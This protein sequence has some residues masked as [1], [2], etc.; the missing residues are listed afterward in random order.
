[1]YLF[2]FRFFSYLA[3]IVYWAEFSVL[4]V[5]KKLI[6]CLMDLRMVIRPSTNSKHLICYQAFHGGS[7]G[8]ES[9]CSAWTEELMGLDR[10]EWLKLSLSHLLP[11]NMWV[12]YTVHGVLMTRVCVL[13]TQS[14]PTL[15]DPMDGSLSGSSV[16]AEYCSHL[17]SPPPMDHVLVEDREV[18]SAA[19][20]GVKESQTQ[21]SDWATTI[22]YLEL[23]RWLSGKESACQCRRW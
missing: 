1:M 10:I 5:N 16:H 18:W 2:F 15:C 12:F 4:L 6:F 20:H 3:T 11:A 22:C 21:L 14:C 17:P 9:D 7:D 8:K 19:V 13:V 23:P